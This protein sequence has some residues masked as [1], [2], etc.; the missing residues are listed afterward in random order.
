MVCA[1]VKIMPFYT[2]ANAMQGPRIH[3]LT[4]I[5]V[6]FAATALC[7]ILQSFGVFWPDYYNV[8]LEDDASYDYGPYFRVGLFQV[9]HSL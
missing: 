9:S 5:T 1:C 7:V 8:D 6:A 4:I 3:G 2:C